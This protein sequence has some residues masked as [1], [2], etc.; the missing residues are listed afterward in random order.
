MP[1]ELEY[2]GY[3]KIKLKIILKKLIDKYIN[4]DFVLIFKSH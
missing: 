2:M 4:G 1:K 3:K